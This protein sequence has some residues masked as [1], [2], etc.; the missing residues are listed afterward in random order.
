ME[1]THLHIEVNSHAFSP[2][3]RGFRPKNH[4]FV[5]HVADRSYVGLYISLGLEVCKRAGRCA[6][7]NTVSIR[8]ASG[9]AD[10]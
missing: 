3:Y 7:G 5:S 10:G 2:S 8:A 9:E 4:D 1:N 6:A